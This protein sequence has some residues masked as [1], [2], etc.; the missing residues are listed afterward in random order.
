MMLGIFTL[1]Y[2]SITFFVGIKI[3]TKYFAVRDKIFLYAG[4]SV[5]GLAT[6][7]AG[8]VLNFISIVF[9]DT[10][11]SMQLHFFLHGF[12]IP[13]ATCFWLMVLMHFSK[14]SKTTR[15]KLIII[16]FIIA[17]IVE[18]AYISI[19][20]IDTAILG[21]LI[22]EIQVDYA[23]FSEIYLLIA[24]I[25]AFF[26]GLWLGKLLRKS[27]KEKV[28]LQG[29][30][31]ISSYC[32]FAFAAFFEV[33]VPIIL[34]IIFARILVTFMSILFYG[35][36]VLPKW[37]MRLF[38]NQKAQ[39]VLKVQEEYE[40]PEELKDDALEFFKII[41]QRRNVTAKEVNF[42]RDKNICL[43]CKGKVE[44]DSAHTCTK[45]YALYCERCALAISQL[46][47]SC[48]ACNEAIDK[49]KPIKLIESKEERKKIIVKMEKVKKKNS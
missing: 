22:N 32:I 10:L 2:V 30:L 14:L 41:S 6:P 35:A 8:V 17:L 15:K 48:W 23:T 12:Y 11:P 4:L 29:K 19:I 34:V 1:I 37:I 39:D 40:E 31:I 21:T 9:F 27:D 49:S 24:T 42:Y 5:I 18:I 45:C 25:I 36:F 47:N 28:R 16:C 7:W 46:E 43:V 38:L 13:I 26:S 44:K 33:L 20:F 3:I